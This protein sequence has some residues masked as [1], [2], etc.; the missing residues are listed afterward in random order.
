M[1]WMEDTPAIKSFL[2]PKW[3][4]APEHS[5]RYPGFVALNRDWALQVDDGII[6]VSSPLKPPTLLSPAF[7]RHSNPPRTAT[8]R[9]PINYFFF[10]SSDMMIICI[11]SGIVFPFCIT[12]LLYISQL[13]PPLPR[14]FLGCWSLVINECFWHSP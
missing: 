12:A 11:S 7:Y 3:M 6:H 9:G 1:E 8:I 4:T 14:R 5:L 10:S 13:P 2:R